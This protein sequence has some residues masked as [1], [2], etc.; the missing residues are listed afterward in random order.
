M[1]FLRF[2]CISLGQIS[3]CQNVCLTSLIL[4][5]LF[6]TLHYSADLWCTLLC[7]IILCSTPSLLSLV[8]LKSP[9]PC[10]VLVYSALFCYTLLHPTI[11]A[12]TL[13]YTLLY[14]TNITFMF[15]PVLCCY[16]LCSLSRDF[17][18]YFLLGGFQEEIRGRKK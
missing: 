6:I 2:S 18:L 16:L 8:V 14:T 11:R 1:P 10:F 4:Q 17:E 15:P 12:C 5:L 7:P 13:L 9:V 3:F